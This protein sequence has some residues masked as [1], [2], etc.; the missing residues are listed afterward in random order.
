MTLTIKKRTNNEIHIKLYILQIKYV[1]EYITLVTCI[2]SKQ[3]YYSMDIDKKNINIFNTPLV[4]L[5]KTASNF[6]A[7]S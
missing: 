2:Y 4:M 6:N 3:K 7:G 5:S 1:T